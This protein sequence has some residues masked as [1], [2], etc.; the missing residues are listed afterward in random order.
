M[1]QAKK[2]Y[3]RT[4]EMSKEKV[5]KKEDES[6]EKLFSVCMEQEDDKMKFSAV[7][8]V[9]N[10]L[11]PERLEPDRPDDSSSCTDIQEDALSS[12]ESDSFNS[13]SSDII[14][15]LLEEEEAWEASH[16]NDLQDTE[17]SPRQTRRT[18]PESAE[19]EPR[20]K[21]NRN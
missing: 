10:H 20:N 18:R 16:K 9:I 15:D 8:L 4:V 13:S 3:K 19:M 12:S 14:R 7:P 2:G 5:T 6:T 17:I 21:R 1:D 11:P